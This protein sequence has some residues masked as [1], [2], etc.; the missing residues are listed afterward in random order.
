MSETSYC[1][2]RLP[3]AVHKAKR[4]SVKANREVIV[5]AGAINSPQ[6]LML[7]GV[8]APDELKAHGIALIHAL[9]GAKVLQSF[10]S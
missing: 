7:S 5:S 3:E 6:L 1:N 8:G 9:P 10:G 4:V 2:G